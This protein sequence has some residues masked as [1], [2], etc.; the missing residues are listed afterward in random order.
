LFYVLALVP[1][2]NANEY[3]VLDQK[4]ANSMVKSELERLAAN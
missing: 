3:F 2:G 4:R 1:V